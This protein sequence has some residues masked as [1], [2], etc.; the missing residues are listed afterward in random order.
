ML[1]LS[2]M[3]HGAPYT[4]AVQTLLEQFQAERHCE[5]RLHIMPW[6]G[7]WAEFVRVALYSDG[8]DVSELGST[9]VSEF[10][11]M[12]ALRP[13]VG[14]DITRIG[15]VARFLPAA[16]SSST[17]HSQQM[18]TLTWAIPWQA[19]TRVLYYRRDIVE[20]AGIDPQTAFQTT[21]ALKQTLAQLQ[22]AGVP[23][24][25]VVPTRRSRMTLH[26]AA[27]WVWGAGGDFVA[28]DRKRTT[29]ME[30]PARAGFGAYFDLARHLAP[31]ARDLAELES[32]ELFWK[33]QAAVT[34]SGAWLLRANSA[35]PEVL[36]NASS[37]RLPGTAYVGGS[38]LGIWKH[39]RQPELALSLVQ[40]L[41]NPTA[42]NIIFEK[43]GLLPTHLDVLTGETFARDPFYQVVSESLRLGRPF[44]PFTLWG[45]VENRLTEA[46][47]AVWV[48]VLATPEPDI[49][50]VIER[51]LGPVATRL[52]FTLSYQ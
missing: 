4:E 31:S 51:H 27:S 50:A 49:A 19:D 6:R 48:E 46:L 22:A 45:L 13:F 5:V 25:W 36:A 44:P 3:D 52:D 15:G 42:Q 1:E 12:N 16:W 37:T 26:N 47:A 34:V 8:P 33:G 18:P 38:H 28:L 10:V 2:I 7:A 23:I 35:A 21:T 40:F 9:W 32:D 30:P 29:F 24:P 39:T 43:A 14:A 20:R 17:P 41:A 11:S